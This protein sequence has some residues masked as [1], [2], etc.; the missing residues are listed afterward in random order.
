MDEQRDLIEQLLSEIS[1]AATP[2][3]SP[4][5]PESRAAQSLLDAISL[6]LI[7]RLVRDI[8]LNSPGNKPNDLASL[9]PE[10]LGGYRYFALYGFG[11]HA[12]SIP[13][14]EMDLMRARLS[15]MMTDSCLVVFDIELDNT[16]EDAPI[17]SFYLNFNNRP[18]KEAFVAVATVRSGINDKILKRPAYHELKRKDHSSWEE[19]LDQALEKLQASMVTNTLAEISLPG[20]PSAKKTLVCPNWEYIRQLREN[21]GPMESVCRVKIITASCPASHTL[22]KTTLI[23]LE[24]G[25]PVRPSTIEDIAK[26]LKVAPKRLIFENI[27]PSVEKL[28]ELREAVVC[29]EEEL[30]RQFGCVTM[31]FFNLLEETAVVPA[32]TMRYVYHHYKE[33]LGS[34]AGTFSELINLPR[35]EA[36]TGQT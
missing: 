1:A 26:V 30:L 20:L 36:L 28:R 16:P 24:R 5:N 33:L 12:Q 10:D 9:A 25:D 27:A 13:K 8:V 19:A 22:S 11:R 31:D 17:R 6:P 7:D 35:T 23:K 21:V 29:T 3:H 34:Q 14:H 15:N 2:S 4:G 18:K 32:E